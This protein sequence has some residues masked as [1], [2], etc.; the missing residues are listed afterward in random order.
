M[1]P[2]VFERPSPARRKARRELDINPYT[3]QL[4]HPSV[5]REIPF[6]ER[7]TCTV[8]EACRASGLGRT[9]LYELFDDDRIK[10]FTVGRRRLVHV[11]SLLK[12]LKFRES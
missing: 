6:A 5:H 9:K 11:P 2:E 8:K 4:A 3:D 10:S 1:S 7:P 12:F